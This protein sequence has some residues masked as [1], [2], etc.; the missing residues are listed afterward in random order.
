L[1]TLANMSGGGD[2]GDRADPDVV[3]SLRDAQSLM[4]PEATMYYA[5]KTIKLMT[6]D[7]HIQGIADI[8]IQRWED[9]EKSVKESSDLPPPELI[10][11]PDIALGT[12][13]DQM[14][15]VD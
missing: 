14:R 9:A 3:A 2:R 12:G 13:E 1:Q 8:A 15:P 10:S 7:R 6:S 11:Q 4:T 5:L